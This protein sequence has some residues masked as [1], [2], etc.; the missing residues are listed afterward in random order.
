MSEKRIVKHFKKIMNVKKVQVPNTL[1]LVEYQTHR[2]P[3]FK[4]VVSLPALVHQLHVASLVRVGGVHLL[5]LQKG[6]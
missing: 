6:N 5:I 1:W 4:L 3:L 2:L